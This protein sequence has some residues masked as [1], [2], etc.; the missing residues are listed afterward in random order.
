MECRLLQTSEIT[1]DS[2]SG[3][4][5]L[6][7]QT[8]GVQMSLPSFDTS[9]RTRGAKIGIERNKKKVIKKKLS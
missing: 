3:W 6:K 2:I 4:V 5:E 7:G 8:M 1:R 9:C